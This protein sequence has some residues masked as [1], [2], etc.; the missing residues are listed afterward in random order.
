MINLVLDTNVWISAL[1]WIG[2]SAKFIGLI[3]KNKIKV[4]ISED[5]INEI[6][7]V[8]L[9]EKKFQI[10]LE[11]KNKRIN[12]IIDYVQE[13]ATLIKIKSKIDFIKD[14][15][16]DNKIVACALDSKSKYLISYDNHLLKLKEY[17]DIKILNP[18]EFF[19]IVK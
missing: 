11:D 2:E 8:L 19:R 14:H 15:S 16:A 1:F 12:E 18:T 5:I 4:F 7:N 6:K 17:K 3:D 9:K 10:M 13:L